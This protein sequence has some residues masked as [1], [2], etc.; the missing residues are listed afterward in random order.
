MLL[1]VLT[2]RY[3][4]HSPSDASSYRTKEEMAA[5][6]A[7]DPINTYRAQ[8]IEAGVATAEECDA[9]KAH[10]KATNL[11]N[12]KLAI[13]DSV[14]PRMNLDKNPDEIAD[15]MFSNGHVEA[16]SDAKPDV[17]MPLEE[18]PRVQA[19]AKKERW[20]FDANGKPVSKNK[21][22]QLRDGLF[23][24]I[25]DRFYKDP[26]MVAYGEENRD[27]GGAFAVYRGLTEAL[28]YHRL[29]NAP[30]SE[31][32]I[33][34]S[35]V[36]YAMAGGRALVELMY[37]DFLG[38][39]G[40]EVFN[41]MAKWQAM[42][43]GIIK[44]PVVLRVSVGSKYGAQHSQ[45][46]TALVAHIPGLKAA[47]PTT[48]YDAKGMLAAALAGTDPVI[49]FESQRIYDVGEQFHEGGVPAEYYE[50]PFGKA[51]IKRPGKDITILTFGAVM[52]RA[53]KAAD[54]LKEKYGMEAEVIDARSLVPF[55]Y[56]TVLE[57]VKKTGRLVIVTD[58]CER[59]SF[60][61]EVARQ[62]TE[63]AFDYLDAAPTV[64]ASRN[65]ITPAHELEE[66]FF[67]QPSWILDAIDAKIV[68]LKGHVRTTNQ[69][70][71][72]KLRNER[73]GV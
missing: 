7:I 49:F 38:C 22:Y 60:A 34:G 8:L 10:V 6:E 59:G 3:A 37:C 61:S 2:Y 15:L 9:I 35:A 53:L 72:E 51:D 12:F 70:L 65:W 16:F 68:P 21:V 69:A 1:D 71:N 31:S 30:I 26:T 55:D 62:I 17:L 50:I 29:F 42:S 11:R 54:E 19:I 25:A 13:D 58:A 5:W 14:S 43:A 64:V 46:W 20:G 33:V 67:P 73:R 63:M 32:A 57:S 66:S 45:D 24:A 18:N 44:M 36:G 28:P 23:E 48:P 47:F 39:A 27:W 41:Q 56:D 40:D 4:G 52:Y